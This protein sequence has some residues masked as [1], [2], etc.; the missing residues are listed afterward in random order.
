MVY[1]DRSYALEREKPE[2]KEGVPPPLIFGVHRCF[3]VDVLG[4]FGAPELTRLFC[5]MDDVVFE[6]IP[7][8]RWE[9]KN[10]IGRGG[11]FCDFRYYRDEPGKT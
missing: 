7:G 4:R 10:T 1:P 6:N 11:E 5:D 3:Y 8:V 9:R 2:N